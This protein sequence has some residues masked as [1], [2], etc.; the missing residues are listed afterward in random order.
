MKIIYG[1]LVTLAVVVLIGLLLGYPTM[2]MVNYLFTPS[3]ISSLFGVAQLTFWRAFWLNCLC[4]TLFK[5]T[6]SSSTK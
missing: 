5:G 1:I 6:S 4:A 3:I 2:W